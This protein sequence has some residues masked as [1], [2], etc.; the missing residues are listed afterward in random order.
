M[1]QDN[2]S[3]SEVLA[4][5]LRAEI[6]AQSLYEHLSERARQVRAKE[7]FALLATEE[8]QHQDM[9]EKK[10]AELF[11]EIPLK[12]PP[13]LLPPALQSLDL[14]KEPDLAEALKVAIAAEQGSRKI[15]LECVDK[16]EDAATKAM[17]RYLAQWEHTH[18]VMLTAEYDLL[19]NFPGNYG[20]S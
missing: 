17:L 11:P 18:E 16:V 2:L 10:Y 1:A 6:D 5:A 19:M 9:L 12:L 4:L 15:Y 14:S 20:V 3:S 8:R 13:S 7:R